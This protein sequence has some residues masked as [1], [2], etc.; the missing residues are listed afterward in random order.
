MKI[1]YISSPPF[2]DFSIEYIQELKK[3][4]TL[5][6]YIV[7]NKQYLQSTIL[8]I[9]QYN[10]KIGELV[11]ID[12]LKDDVEH[13]DLL[14]EYI[15][16]CNSFNFVLF[17]DKSLSFAA[18]QSSRKLAA[19]I[20]KSIPSVVHFDDIHLQLLGLRVFLK[21]RN[22]VTNVHDPEPHSGENNWR[23]IFIR[24]VF[25]PVMKSF[26]LFSN[27]S[28]DRF[29]KIYDPLQQVNTLSLTPYYFYK[30]LPKQSIHL[31]LSTSD[32]VLL[33]FGRISKYKGVGQLL[34][35]FYHLNDKYPNLRLI[36]AGKGK[37]DGEILAESGDETN[38]KLI[39]INRFINNRE[40]VYLMG[41]T[42]IVVCPYRDATQS[43]VV[44]TAFAFEKKVIVSKVGGLYEP[45]IENKNGYIY[46]L[47]DPN[48]LE[49][50]IEKAI[51]KKSYNTEFSNNLKIEASVNIEKLIK[52]YDK[53]VSNC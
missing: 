8:N 40:L 20:N 30:E 53:V 25:Y 11:T 24:K 33:F 32:F 15:D 38:G 5:D 2:L 46:N 3:E 48:S 6:V 17:P 34:K 14:K 27:Y 29:I 22:L 10:Y 1:A 49:N 35:A 4:V 16:G 41:K 12:D 50:V 31:D 36:I 43:G 26:I 19:F 45:V 52:I 21:S 42:D 23:R 51:T 18:L 37:L 7:L 39:V 47:N 44:M 13:Y 28:K 9:K